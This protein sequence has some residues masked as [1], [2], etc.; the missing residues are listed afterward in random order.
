MH[1][2]VIVALL[3]TGLATPALPQSPNTYGQRALARLA[4]K[5]AA[6]PKLPDSLRRLAPRD[7]LALPESGYVRILNDSQASD[8]MDVM[9]A[10]LHQLPDSLCGRFL[11]AG[12]N[13]P[14]LAAMFVLID[15]AT[16]DRW[17]PILE[18][19]VRA[20]GRS[21][22]AGRAANAEE[23]RAANIAVITGMDSTRRQRFGW[24]AQHPPPSPADACWSMRTIMDAMAQLPPAQL[25]PV[26]RANFG[27]PK[28][29]K[30]GKERE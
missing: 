12:A 19:I 23:I 18:R 30:H 2:S 9:A 3:L 8:F 28:R 27:M 15:S 24:I 16:V 1:R 25:G 20:A 26:V 4:Q 22:P 11:I 13:P 17:I 14:D 5:L 29:T 21:E 10:T 6:D 7:L